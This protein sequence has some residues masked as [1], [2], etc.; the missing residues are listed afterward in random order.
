VAVLTYAAT[1]L[2]TL[3]E[4]VR[5]PEWA[6]Q[7]RTVVMAV[8]VM[9]L[10]FMLSLYMGQRKRSR[11]DKYFVDAIKSKRAALPVIDY[12]GRD[13]RLL[14]HFGLAALPNNLTVLVYLYVSSALLRRRNQVPKY[15]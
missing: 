13:Q 2:W 10:L 9:Y 4:L 3:S 11:D 5:D 6:Q 7:D 14:I 1:Q 8:G 12:L 15:P